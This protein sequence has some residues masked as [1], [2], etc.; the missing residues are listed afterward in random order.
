MIRKRNIVRSL[1]KAIHNPGYALSVFFKR[2]ISFASYKFLN[3]KSAYPETISLF[4]TYKCNLRCKMCGQWGENGWAKCQPPEITGKT[5]PVDTIKRM[6]DDT[7]FFKPNITLFGGEP[8][9]FKDWEEVVRHIKKRKLRVNMI[10]NGTLLS[11]Y[12]EKVVDSGIDEI[13]FSLDG[14]EEIHDEIRSGKGIFKKATESFMMLK[15][16]KEKKGISTPRVNVNTTI[17]ED[18]YRRLDEIISVAESIGADTLTFHHL[19]FLSDKICNDNSRFM[20]NELNLECMDW[21]GFSMDRLPEI[22]PDYLVEKLKELKSRKS[23][24]S[25]NVYPNFTEEETKKYYSNF[26]FRSETYS[27][28]CISPWMTVYV[29]PNGDIKP[30]LDVSYIAG[31]ILEER[32]PEIWN[33]EKLKQYRRVLK[34]HGIFPGCIRCTELY[35]A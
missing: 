28:R 10:T 26:E 3:G 18:N 25:I 4:L 21:K 35:R 5:L 31:N 8:L 14:P 6:I 22:D 20:K 29:F 24:V 13:I 9:L 30:C 17:F 11:Q 33:G 7:A 34:K 16:Y 27:T 15:D 32:F 12:V 19:I 1:Q 2:F 23:K